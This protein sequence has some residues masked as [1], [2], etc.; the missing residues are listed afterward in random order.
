[1]PK[2]NKHFDTLEIYKDLDNIYMN[3]SLNV[4]Y[5]VK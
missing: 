5:K 2:Y 3:N 1:M 4:D